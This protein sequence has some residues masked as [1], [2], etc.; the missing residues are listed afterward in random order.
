M[1][2]TVEMISIAVPLQTL[3]NPKGFTVIG[4]ASI[5]TTH[6]WTNV[7]C[8]GAGGPLPKTGTGANRL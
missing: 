4:N 3:R 2:T 6:T 1:T 7:V 8:E 5:Q